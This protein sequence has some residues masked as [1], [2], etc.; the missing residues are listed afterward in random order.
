MA[1]TR[2]R[3]NRIGDRRNSNARSIASTSP[4]SSLQIEIDFGGTLATMIAIR[5]DLAVTGYAK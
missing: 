5:K 4:K 2:S 1:Q 3:R